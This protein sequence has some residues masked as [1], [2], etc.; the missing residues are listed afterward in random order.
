[1]PI[2]IETQRVMDASQAA[3]SQSFSQQEINNIAYFINVASGKANNLT[4]EE[5][6]SLETFFENAVNN[7]S[8][9]KKVSKAIK[10]MPPELDNM[11]T[12]LGYIRNFCYKT[13]FVDNIEGINK[14]TVRNLELL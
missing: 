8:L 9:N 12:A 4:N 13:R 11:A 1:M 14:K 10:S 3:L 6:V 2:S 7:Q 5:K